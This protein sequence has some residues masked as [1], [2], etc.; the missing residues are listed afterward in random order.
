MVCCPDFSKT[1]SVFLNNVEVTDAPLV[2]LKLDLVGSGWLVSNIN[3]IKLWCPLLANL[4]HNRLFWTF[5]EENPAGGD[6][7][8]HHG[9][10]YTGRSPLSLIIENAIICHR[11]ATANHFM[12]YGGFV[13]FNYKLFNSII[14]RVVF[15]R[16]FCITAIPKIWYFLD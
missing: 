3:K 1:A 7:L 4:P 5:Q 12:H 2:I 15:D 10:A 6:H 9:E 11:N 14:V 13:H 16:I 8:H